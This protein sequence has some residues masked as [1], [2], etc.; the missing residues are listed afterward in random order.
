MPDATH[1]VE[2]TSAAGPLPSSSRRTDGDCPQR[3]PYSDCLDADRGALPQSAPGFLVAAY[4]FGIPGRAAAAPPPRPC[5]RPPSAGISST[6]PCASLRL[7]DKAVPPAG[8]RPRLASPA[9]DP[10]HPSSS[11]TRPCHPPAPTLLPIMGDCGRGAGESSMHEQMEQR[12]GAS[13]T[14][15]S[16]G[17]SGVL[18]G[19]PVAVH[20]AA[21]TTPRATPRCS[22]ASDVRSFDG[23]RHRG[24]EQRI[25]AGPAYVAA[26]H[27]LSSLL[28]STY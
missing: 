17:R 19:S 2:R 3:R 11:A 12:R 1:P 5:W 21:D 18:C 10:A 16:A 7:R 28:S 4:G 26:T 24:R 25:D 27:S 6:G 20:C 14:G 15:P 8:A 22:V 23:V 9:P 13:R